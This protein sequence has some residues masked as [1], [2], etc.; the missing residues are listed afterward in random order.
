MNIQVFCLLLKLFVYLFSKAISNNLA[1]QSKTFIL[2]IIVLAQFFCCSS[3]FAVNA[4]IEEIQVLLQASPSF[5]ANA[6]TSVQLGFIVGT[7]IYAILSLADRYSPSRVFFFSAVIASVFNAMILIE[8]I[9]TF[10]VLTCRFVVGFFLAGIYPV[11]MKIASD[12]FKE[13]LGVSLGYLVGA[14]VLGTALPHFISAMNWGIGW[15]TVVYTTS[16]LT[17]I[18]GLS[19]L[20]FVPDGPFL[21]KA[22]KFQFGQ[23]KTIFQ[24]QPFN[25]AAMGYFGH[26]WE[27]Y[28]FWAFVPIYIQAY[29]K[30]TPSLTTN[31]SLITFGVIGIGG[32]ACVLG[33][34][35]AR[36][37]GAQKSAGIFLSLSGICCLLSPIVFNHASYYPFLIF[38]LFWGMV[39]IAD[40]P[41]FSTLV[42]QNAPPQSKGTALTI[43]TCIGFALTIVSI[44]LLNLLI[45]YVDVS[46]LFIFLTIG[47]VFGV[48]KLVKS[49]RNKDNGLESSTN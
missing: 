46:F 13:G 29:Q 17:L 20:L 14:L 37:I 44:Q 18:G 2:T 10:G 28:A 43:V 21:K 40:S 47:P 3:W 26:M 24:N 42:A 41:L 36:K 30:D 15:H 11:G 1:N 5:L 8:G 16:A 9:G 27:L 45:S 39:V 34:Y 35:L 48:W 12:Y 19:I 23:L 32:L 25:R 49:N 4:I 31:I 6:T 22:L 7:L 38:I 33:G